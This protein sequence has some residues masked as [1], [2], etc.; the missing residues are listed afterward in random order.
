MNKKIFLIGNND[1][2]PGVKK[3][4]LNYETFFTSEIGGNW[5]GSEIISK[6]NPTESELKTE[7]QKLKAANLDFL[8]IIFSGHA[9]QEREVILEINGNG[10]LISESELKNLARRQLNIYDCCRAP[11]SLVEFSES[12]REL[13]T[14]SAQFRT[15]IRKLYEE[16]IM[17]AIPQQLYLYACSIG[18]TAEDTSLGGLYSVNL[19]HAAKNIVNDYMTVG[20]AHQ[21]AASE[22]KKNR[23]D[24]N[25]DSVLV[26]C[27]SS[28]ELI[29]SI[30]PSLG[31][32]N[33]F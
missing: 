14:K 1:G 10:D 18:E 6:M 25:P 19:I 28:Q 9:G 4:F 26:R 29:L 22:T 21:L 11:I 12:E 31:R 30:N 2:L 23:G 15:N 20:Q 5:N 33:L 24:Q 16:R 8:I 3:D 17:Q 32:K 27:L 7:L 13:M